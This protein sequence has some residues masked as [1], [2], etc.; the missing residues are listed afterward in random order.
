MRGGQLFRSLC[1]CRQAEPFT[2][3]GDC[4][5]GDG[6]APGDS[7]VLATEASFEALRLK[8]SSGF[9]RREQ[10]EIDVHRLELAFSR[11]V[12]G[13]DMT[14]CDV[15]QQRAEGGCDRRQRER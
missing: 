5:R 2:A 8:L 13:D 11:L 7:L 4:A 15:V 10:P 1:P 9:E 14:A 12:V 6:V 3:V